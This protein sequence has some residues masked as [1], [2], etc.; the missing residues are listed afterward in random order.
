MISR[1]RMPR[2]D[3]DRKRS[4][5]RVLREE[6]MRKSAL[7][8]LLMLSAA[9]TQVGCILPIFSSSPD[10]RAKQ[11][12]FTSEGYRHIPEVWERIWFLDMPDVM[13]PYRTHG[14]V[15]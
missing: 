5:F 13:T 9:I 10:V 8:G 2:C 6:I 7:L 12:I 11:L 4:A 3:F 15:I 14:G 1:Y